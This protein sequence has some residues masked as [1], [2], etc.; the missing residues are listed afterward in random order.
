[1]VPRASDR[2]ILT[3]ELL[4]IGTELTVGETRD[5]N[6][7][8]LARELTTMGV[9]VLRISALPDDL[10]SVRD[11]FATATVRSDLV[12]S[13]GGLGPTPDDL[14]REAI[15]ATI[16]ET[17][18]VD[19]DLERWLRAIW[20]RRG[21]TFQEINL[22]QAWLV[23]SATAL[24]NPNGTAP[25]WW[26]AR[27]DGGLIVA[28]PGPPKEMR[29]MWTDEVLPRLRER[30]LGLV[31]ASRTLRLAGIGESQVAAELGETILRATDPVVA[32][33]ARADAVDVR[34]SARGHGPDG[35]PPEARVA[36][37]AHRVGVTL[38]GHVW[39]EGATSWA[40]AIGDALGDAGGSLAVVEVG[41]GGSLAALLGDRD[42][43]TFMEA[44]GAGTATA[45]S[46]GTN[47]GLEHLARR[48]RELGEATHAV[49]VRARPRGADTAVAVVVV[50]P[51]W[52][53]RERRVVFLGGATGRQRASLAA[54][55]IA[56][57]AIRER[58]SG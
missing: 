17:P 20:D 14:T 11:A 47:D 9:A 52:V 34:I 4:S 46:H 3:A 41:T 19:P 45:R 27:R 6:A 49:A 58:A 1:V 21:L 10:G 24:A 48:G 54:A 51:D 42:W 55:H 8:D 26:V 22:K 35:S 30:G 53:H 13:T 18:A 29:P 56:L 37:M 39:A 40:D 43:L 28:L 38:A 15:A 50:G 31:G 12:V 2:P 57:T 33:Y 36:E 32:T 5:T 16:G 25:G 44:L 7:G 23:P